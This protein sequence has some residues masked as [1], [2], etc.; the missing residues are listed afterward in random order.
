MTAHAYG[1]EG[2]AKLGQSGWFYLPPGLGYVVTRLR[3]NS[4]CAIEDVRMGQVFESVVSVNSLCPL[5]GGENVNH[6]SLYGTQ[7]EEP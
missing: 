7:Y 5:D 1:L 3:S 4:E 6:H 2:I